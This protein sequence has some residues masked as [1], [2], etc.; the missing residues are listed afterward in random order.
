MVAIGVARGTADAK[1][2]DEDAQKRWDEDEA[3]RA[4][5][6]RSR[7]MVALAIGACVWCAAAAVVVVVCV[8]RVCGR[9]WCLTVRKARVFGG[10]V[11]WQMKDRQMRL[12]LLHMTRAAASKAP[13]P[14]QSK[15]NRGQ[16]HPIHVPKAAAVAT[17]T[18]V[19]AKKEKPRTPE[20]EI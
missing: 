1:V 7:C 9:R 16:I 8:V 10:R 12:L 5:W 13:D 20:L 2:R 14:S 4:V 6:R 18:S 3:A 15:A 17:E 11:G 19:L